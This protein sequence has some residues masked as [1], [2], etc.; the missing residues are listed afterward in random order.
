MFRP[1]V[2]SSA[3]LIAT[4]GLT[5]CGGGSST[6]SP[7]PVVPV[8]PV[9]PTLPTPVAVGDTVALTNSGALISFNRASPATLVGT[10]AVTG[11]A[12][13]ESLVGIDVRPANN[14][15]YALGSLGNLYTVVP[16][17]G[18]A[19]QVAKL[20]ADAADLT[21]P[22]TALSG[23][24][25]GIDFNPVADRLRVISNNGQDLRINVETGATTTDGD[26]TPAGNV[27]SGSGYTNS[28]AG[29]TNTRLFNINLTT[30]TLDLQDPP[31]NG[32]QVSGPALGVTPTAADFDIDA[33]NNIGYASITVGGASSLYQVN[34]QTG[35]AAPAATLVG[36]IAGGEP[37]RSIALV[38]AAAP[39]VTGLTTSNGL[40]TFSPRTP[41][42]IS[43][44][45]PITGLG[46][47]ENI[48]GIDVRPQD[49]L[50]WALSSTGRLYTLD[51][52]TGAATFKV[53]ISATLDGSPNA[54]VDFNPAAN[55]LRVVTSG[56]QNLRIAV[57]D[58]PAAGATPAV[59]AGTTI[60]D[61]AINRTGGAPSLV[62]AAA[63]SNNFAP[64]TGLTPATVL[65]DIDATADV[66]AQQAPP[67]NGTLVDV[68]PL[69]IDINTAASFDIAGGEN[70]MV[71]GAVQAA[72]TGPFLLRSLNLATGAVG[73]YNFTSTGTPTTDALSQI[74]GATGPAVRDIA[75]TLKK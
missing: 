38:Q 51:A 16:S 65:F 15:L 10:I 45:V 47:G 9:I 12:S 7:A 43:A 4:L 39:Q 54:S 64:V 2:L 23:T 58:I 55:R 18:V 29:A 41:N 1:S 17:T 57:V 32:S 75:I 36:A 60:T 40:F 30:S 42:T 46:V 52:A 27:I 21:A 25:F 22:F 69:G 67:N 63:Y 66:L 73:P 70:G 37:V 53:A 72:N 56:G 35:A 28:F 24:S 59:A 62:V 8:P 50:L 68:G 20:A 14:T 74:G 5:A 19:T 44:V 3:V 13:G 26:I 48:L 34:M 31:N 71:L 6:S 61:G 33:L 49:G 11:L